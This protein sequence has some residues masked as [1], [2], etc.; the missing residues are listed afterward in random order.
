MRWLS[1]NCISDNNLEEFLSH[2]A[3]SDPVENC[4][5]W[6]QAMPA[7]FLSHVVMKSYAAC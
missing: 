6:S 7:Q 4:F 5:L 1:I 2:V 3:D